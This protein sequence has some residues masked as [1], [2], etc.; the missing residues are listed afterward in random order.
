MLSTPAVSNRL[1]PYSRIIARIVWHFI[2][3]FNEPVF[4]KTKIL[5]GEAI[6]SMGFSRKNGQWTKTATIKNW[7]TLVAPKNHKMLNYV[8]PADQ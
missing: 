4:G 6:T 2:V 3:F 7:D 5:R 8:N 1:L